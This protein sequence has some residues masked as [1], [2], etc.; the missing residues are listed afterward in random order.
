[1]RYQLRYVRV[2]ARPVVHPATMN[3]SRPVIPHAKPVSGSGVSPGIGSGGSGGEAGAALE[4]GV[5]LAEL[6]RGGAGEQ[7]GL[8][9]V[10]DDGGQ[11]FPLVTVRFRTVSQDAGLGALG[12][13]V[14]EEVGEAVRD[15]TWGR[16]SPIPAGCG[17]GRR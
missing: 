3:S 4:A 15:V 13:A 11:E 10:G 16:A 14:P 8:A 17:R 5:P 9:G 12:G 6:G 1:M 2:L 7:G